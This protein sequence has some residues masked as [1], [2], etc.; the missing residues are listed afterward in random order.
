MEG[1]EGRG[2]LV[3]RGPAPRRWLIVAALVVAVAALLLLA[4]RVTGDNGGETLETPT[5]TIVGS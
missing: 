4:L 3:D 5:S 2:R 1:E